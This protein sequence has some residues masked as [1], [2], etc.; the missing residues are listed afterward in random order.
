MVP[1]SSTALVAVSS[2]AAVQGFVAA[3]PHMRIP[4]QKCMHQQVVNHVLHAL[5]TALD[6]VAAMRLQT[7]Q[8][9]SAALSDVDEVDEVLAQHS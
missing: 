8:C 2:A 6:T 9:V 1:A 5:F 4:L 3:S 7:Q